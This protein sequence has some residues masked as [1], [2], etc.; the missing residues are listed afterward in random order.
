MHKCRC[1]LTLFEL[2][3][4]LFWRHWHCICVRWLDPGRHI[5]LM[6]LANTFWNSCFLEKFIQ[7]IDRIAWLILHG[8]I[9]IGGNEFSCTGIKWEKQDIFVPH[10]R[11]GGREKGASASATWHLFSTGSQMLCFTTKKRINTPWGIWT[12]DYS[13][14]V[15]PL[16]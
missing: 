15:Y 16:S 1:T 6:C 13:S 11:E 9:I 14:M 8:F 12:P 3:P 10:V 7:Q 4:L 2:L 5:L